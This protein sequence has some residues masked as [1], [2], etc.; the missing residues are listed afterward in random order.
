[1]FDQSSMCHTDG[2]YRRAT[3]PFDFVSNLSQKILKLD[4]M[5]QSN[6]RRK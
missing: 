3:A 2:K 1:M 5:K 6:L 4:R